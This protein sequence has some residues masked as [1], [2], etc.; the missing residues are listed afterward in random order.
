M[1]IDFLNLPVGSQIPSNVADLASPKKYFNTQA[2]SKIAFIGSS[3][4]GS[5]IPES[6]ILPMLSFNKE[7][8]EIPLYGR[9]EIQFI[10][11]NL[12]PIEAYFR[13]DVEKYGFQE[14]SKNSNNN[15]NNDNNNNDNNDNKTRKKEIDIVNLEEHSYN[16]IIEDGSSTLSIKKGRNCIVRFS[17]AVININEKHR[18]GHNTVHKNLVVTENNK[19]ILTPHE[20]GS[21]KFHSVEGKKF[22]NNRDTKKEN[23]QFLQ[24]GLGCTFIMEPSSGFLPPWGQ[25]IIKVKSYNDMPGIYNDSVSCKIYHKDGV[26]FRDYI[27][28]VAMSVRGCPF[29]IVETSVGMCPSQKDTGNNNTKKI[30]KNKNKKEDKDIV[31]NINFKDDDDEG[32]HSS[33]SSFSGPCLLN[34]GHST[35]N[36]DPL[37]RDFHVKNAGSKVGTISWDC[38]A[39][40]PNVDTDR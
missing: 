11:R 26:L 10:V 27:L 7:N 22:L 9:S 38:A 28:P 17:K 24:S 16:S 29:L 13:L 15:N 40:Y 20:D 8:K 23:S 39:L 37:V 33:S 14:K 25:Q 36:S 31:D 18:K 5:K 2:N 6:E 34:M 35:I 12:S 32:E 3:D 30:N 21:N 1:S 19:M 4:S